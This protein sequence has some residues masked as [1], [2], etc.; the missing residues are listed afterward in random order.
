MATISVL[1]LYHEAT[2]TADA[3][4]GLR[5]LGI[6]DE[7]VTIMSGIPYR[8]EMLGRPHEPRPV[9]FIALLGAFLGALLGIFLSIGIFLLY[10]LQQGGQ[11][12]VPIPPTLIILFETTMLG[13][14][15][16]AF[17]GLLG[18]SRFPAMKVTMYDPR[19]TEGHIGVLV[20]IPDTLQEEVEALLQTYGAH[21]M[22]SELADTAP[23]VGRRRFWL[24]VSGS[25]A[26]VTTLILLLAYD[27]LEIPLPTQM[28]SQPSI[29]YIEGPRLAAPA[30]AVP[31]QGPALIS[32]EPASEPVP[33]SSAS[34]QRGAVLFNINCALC[35]GDKGTGD[36]PLAP[37][38]TPHPAD[39]SGEEV[40]KLPDTVLFL[41]LS[42]GRGIMP[43]QYE[44]LNP[45]ERWDVINHVR[46]FSE[47]MEK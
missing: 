15:W 47:G 35:H 16:A 2:P 7:K 13:T 38:F 19:I 39:L 41:V 9:G 23:D 24:V 3:I 18:T 28:E 42:E 46:T 26:I 25:L 27:V 22:H 21:H 33:A 36:G 40:Q 37:F 14:M 30:A 34:L 4:E 43:A 44:N 8:E 45:G 12:I 5:E 1:G 29:A 11:P 20:E 10:P 17:L 32:D 31:V 6:P